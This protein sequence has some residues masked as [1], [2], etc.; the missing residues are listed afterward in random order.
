VRFERDVL[1]AEWV[2]EPGDVLA[3]WIEA[4]TF[5]RHMVRVLVGTMLAGVRPDGFRRL[6]EGRPR[7]EAGATAPPQG[8]YLESVRY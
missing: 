1:R 6:L 4:D 2:E 5:M 7:S 3:F 8:L